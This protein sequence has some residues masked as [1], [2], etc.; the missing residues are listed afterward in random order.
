MMA[1]LVSCLVKNKTTN[2]QGFYLPKKYK[3]FQLVQKSELMILT[4]YKE[5]TP[6]YPEKRLNLIIYDTKKRT[7][8]FNDH[9]K[10]GILEWINDHVIKVS[11]TPGNP[12][13]GES[14]SFYYDL[15]TRTKQPQLQFQK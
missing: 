5:I 4:Q 13:K 1:L 9:Y 2:D 6:K 11:Y 12:Q 3:E 8:L 7:E 10:N 14:Y 15:T